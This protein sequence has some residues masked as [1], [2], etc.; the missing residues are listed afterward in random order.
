ML[1]LL[2]AIAQGS[3]ATDGVRLRGCRVGTPNPQFV[4]R[5]APSLQGGENPY[6]GDRRQLVVLA[7]FQNQDFAEDHDATLA[8]WNKIFNAEGYC[9][10]SYVGSVR[11]YFLAQSYGQFRLT[12]DL[13]F[14]ELPN[15]RQKYRS[16]DIDDE[17]SQY[18][19]DDIV[20]MLLTRDIDW[21][22]YDWDGDRFVDQLLIVYAGKGQNAGGDSNTIWP[23]QWWLS[24]H[25]DL[26]T[27]DVSDFRSFRTVTSGGQ[28]YYI[29][30][31]CC[32]QEIVEIGGISTPFGTL[33]HEYSHCFGFPDFYYGGGTKVV[34]Q[35]DLMDYGNYSGKGFHPCSYSAHERMLMGWLTPV[36]LTTTAAITDMPALEDEPLA[37]LIRNDGA[38]NEYYIVENRQQ[39]GWDE[40]LP[41]SGIVVF[42]VDYDKALWMSTTVEVNSYSKKRY[43]IFPAN[44][45]TSI[46]SS[47]GWAYPY[48][49]TDDQGN[50]SV[51]N[52]CLT[53]TSA[54]A[55][56]LINPNAD[57]QTLMSKPITQMAVDADGLASF[58]FMD[59]QLMLMNGDDNT[60]RIAAT[61]AGINYDVTLQ[62]RTLYRDG[63][64]NT[65]C[66]PFG[67]SSFT[68]T[69]LEGATVM[70]LDNS[71]TCETG[72]DSST[73]TLTLDFVDV[74]K[75]EAGKPYIV[76]WTTL[77]DS[78][79]NPF[80][81]DV[82][83]SDEDPISNKVIST[84]GKLSFVG[85]YSPVAITVG[86]KS[87]LFIGI[88]KNEKDEDVN[89][90]ICPN[91]TNYASLPA[92]IGADANHYYVGAF[93]AWFHVSLEDNA[94]RAYVLHFSDD[95]RVSPTLESSRDGG[96]RGEALLYDLQG[97]RVNNPSH[98]IYIMNGRKII[99]K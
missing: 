70:A 11:D 18:M 38:E 45:K 85:A 68:G 37:Y 4:P 2:C 27:D 16:T 89:T 39:K 88:G 41:G 15:N 53:N 65:L 5:R 46:Y 73:G 13:L 76:K 74:D 52:D 30:S 42:H 35:W 84:D 59:D 22:P 20:D 96:E 60:A 99:V 40:L 91:D 43:H 7:S 12:F 33:C 72:L 6:V 64:W 50:V 93:R 19:V 98:G 86:D 94:I 87:S 95:T 66:L 26:T 36:E 63:G 24:Q 56:T 58:V 48:V 90:L 25:Q 31:Y 29:D 92:L 71:D 17:F 28:E 10:G 69:P 77:D 14:V 78:I 47:K 51:A 23:H 80:F 55:A 83:I 97:R 34:N 3:L 8:T 81:E 54:P 82:T 57:G 44:N 9:E 67:L 1:A 79:V 61:V 32:V 49:V 75:I 62:G 21:S